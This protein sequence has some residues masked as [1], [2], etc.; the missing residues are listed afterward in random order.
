MEV[1]AENVV[2]LDVR[3]IWEYK[4]KHLVNSISIPFNE[5]PDNLEKTL[6]NK[7]IPIIIVCST[8]SRSK[9]AKE[10]A[11]ENGYNNILY[12]GTVEEAEKMQKKII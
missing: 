1:K 10:F 5:L 4:E 11:I 3:N 12:T 6:N 8:G 9:V 2:F 7:N